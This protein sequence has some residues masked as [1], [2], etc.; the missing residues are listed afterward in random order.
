MKR[1]MTI[2]LS[3]VMLLTVIPCFGINALA[4]VSLTTGDIS[5]NGSGS[6]KVAYSYADGVLTIS[7]KG[8]IKSYDNLMDTDVEGGQAEA[9]PFYQTGIKEVVIED[10]ITSIGAGLFA[11][12]A[13][14]KSVTIPDSVTEIC[15]YAFYRCSGLKSIELPGKLKELWYHSFEGCYRLKSVEIPDGVKTIWYNAFSGCEAL[16]TVKLPASLEEIKDYAFEN[17]I[18]LKKAA[19]PS[20]VKTICYAAFQNCASL[21][22]VTIPASVKSIDSNAFYDTDLLDVY[23]LGTKAKWDKIKIGGH[24]R[25][26]KSADRHYIS[27]IEGK[28]VKSFKANAGK[29]QLRLSWSKMTAATGYEIQYATNSK[30]TKNTKT[31]TVK[32]NTTVSKTVKDLKS[33]KKYFVRIRAY[34]T[35]NGVNYYGSWSEAKS[36]KCK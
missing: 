6:D 25:P 18:N 14:L 30:F 10:G 15:P 8:K 4:S 26:L 21:E 36:V 16:K 19:L 24:N 9:S 5:F 33:G 17:C 35:V 3:T 12:C 34:Q 31:V 2:L 29:K 32:K 23:Y 11:E 27:S 22:S 13:S 28:K 20:G 7:G 1:I